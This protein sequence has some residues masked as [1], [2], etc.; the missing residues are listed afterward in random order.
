MIPRLLAALVLVA[1]AM[2][3]VRRRNQRRAAEA[4]RDTNG[5]RDLFGEMQAHFALLED[6][7]EKARYWSDG[8][9]RLAVEH[10]LFKIVHSDEDDD[11]GEQLRQQPERTA[12]HVRRT[13]RDPDLQTRLQK[14][15]R[16]ETPWVRAC[17]LLDSAPS[18]E[19]APFVRDLLDDRGEQV[20]RDAWHWL[21]R[22]GSDEVLDDLLR[23][24]QTPPDA[25][26]RAWVLIGLVAADRDGRV[27]AH[28]RGAL[29]AT[30]LDHLDGYD[31]REVP[32]L[33]LRWNQ[34]RALA[35]FAER[36]LLDQDH[37]DFGYVAQAMATA[38]L[39]LPR[40]Q[41]RTLLAAGP[42]A[43]TT[44]TFRS[45]GTM[46]GALRAPEDEAVLLRLLA[47]SSDA[48]EAAAAG[49]LAY[50][51]IDDW[52]DQLT[53]RQGRWSEAERRID[54]M[55]RV[56]NEVCNGGWE[57][58]FFS[59]A[60]DAWRHALAGFDAAGDDRRAD[61]LREAVARFDTEPSADRD[62]RMEQLSALTKNAD[63]DPFQ[64]IDRRH[65][66]DRVDID[67]VLTRYMLAN[68]RELQQAWHQPTP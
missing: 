27:S 58:Y 28:A 5:E 47:G 60:G 48:A 56:E 35:A 66:E 34:E 31:T 54:A 11:L 40:T 7:R 23:G 36:G 9:V 50:H 62:R 57:Q 38:G 33:L 67:V 59:S 20:R 15:E 45:F 16:G 3:V 24:V 10:Y 44:S 63:D 43:F 22:I 17:R 12:Q 18:A 61:L 6:G 55:R 51:G 2:W 65:L 46:L 37:P 8:E 49:L 25:S 42:E 14:R 26:V 29:F 21:A 53:R 19:N 52:F 68:L 64:T 13:L 1:W 41:L 39:S 30:L 4:A 32:A